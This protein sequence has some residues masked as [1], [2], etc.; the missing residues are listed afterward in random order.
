MEC[1]VQWGQITTSFKKR[2]R[3]SSRINF[4]QLAGWSPRV[5]YFPEGWGQTQAL[6]NG[7]PNSTSS[8]W[9]LE[10][11]NSLSLSPYLTAV[12]TN[13]HSLLINLVSNHWGGCTMRQIDIYRADRHLHL[14]MR[15]SFA[16]ETFLAA[17]TMDENIL[18]FKTH[19]IYI[20]CPQT[21]LCLIL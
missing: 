17:L 15:A 5:C 12:P 8:L 11:G 7:I 10:R 20:T 18:T 14:I 19:S 9:A 6:A 1:P 13:M 21:S 2:R 4:P 3:V 16:V